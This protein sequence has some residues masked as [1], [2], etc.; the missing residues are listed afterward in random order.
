MGTFVRG[1]LATLIFAA[2]LRFVHF[3]VLILKTTE[4]S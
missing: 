3:P 2:V 1:A 4:R